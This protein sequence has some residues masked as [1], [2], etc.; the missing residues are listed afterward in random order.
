[1]NNYSGQIQALQQKGYGIYHWFNE[2]DRELQLFNLNS[3]LTT[4]LTIQC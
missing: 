2:G 1:M 4:R 3:I